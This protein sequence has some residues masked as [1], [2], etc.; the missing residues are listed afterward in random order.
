MAAKKLPKKKAR[1]KSSDAPTAVRPLPSTSGE[2]AKPLSVST[3]EFVRLLA[4]QT[5]SRRTVATGVIAL[6]LGGVGAAVYLWPASPVPTVM[7]PPPV[8]ATPEEPGATPTEQE[9][10]AALRRA[11]KPIASHLNGPSRPAH[12]TPAPP[13]PPPP[14][15]GDT[16]PARIN[17]YDLARAIAADRR[18]AV[19]LCY[20]HELKRNPRLHGR[21]TVD[22]QIKAPRSIGEVRV[23]D[24]LKRSSFTRCVQKAL[25]AIDIPPV[26]EDLVVEIPFAL[27][28]PDL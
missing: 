18:G 6:V 11:P 12:A 27:T 7:D 21:A 25:R 15:G 9:A 3:H 14:P 2:H 23:I 10:K 13:T 26:A 28:S 24:N 17:A 4:L 8:V 19:Q 20:E 1:K 22:L 5:R 16:H